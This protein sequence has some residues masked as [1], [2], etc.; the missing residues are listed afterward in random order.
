MAYSM[1]LR[2]KVLAAYDRGMATKNIA[3]VFGVSASWARRVKQQRREHGQLAPKRR[4][5]GAVP[6]R[7][8][9]LRL[10]P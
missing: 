1:D 10:V 6:P 2:S 7:Y 5:L 3:E 4:G 8:R 9:F